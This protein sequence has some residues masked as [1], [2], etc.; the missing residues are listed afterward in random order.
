V[1][2]GLERIGAIL[3]SL[4]VGIVAVDASGNIELQNAEASR[5][6]GVSAKLARGAPLS[7]V[8]G[9]A[10]PAVALVA[11]ALEAQREVAAHACALPRR[12]L[13]EPPVVDLS[14]SPIGVGDDFEGVVLTLHDRT[15]G[16]ELQALLDQRTRSEVFTQLAAGIAHEVR[17]PLG[18]IRGA[19]ELLLGK[20]D[21]EALRR[22][23]ELIAEESERIRRLLDDLA[24][25]TAGGELQR[26]PINVHRVL[27]DLLELQRHD[28]AWREIE[29]VR[30]YDPSMQRRAGDVGHGAARRSHA[31]REPLPGFRRRAGAGAR[32]LARGRGRRS[33]HPGG[34]PAPCLHP[35][36][37]ATRARQRART[38]HRSA[39][40]RAPRRTAP[41]RKPP[42]RGHARARDASATESTMSRILVADDESSI[43]F[44]LREA[45][46]DRGHEVIEAEDGEEARRRL[47][48][49]PLDI[50]FLDI[51][52]PGASGLDLLA[53]VV[54]RGTEAPVVVIIT[55]QNTFENAIEAMKRGAFD[56][57]TKPFGLA[58]VHALVEKALRQRSL[59]S[60]VAE[61]RR[62]VGEVF[63]AGEALVGRS[64][65]MVETFKTIGRVAASEAAVLIRGESGT[66]KELIARAIHYHSAR[67]EGPFVAVNMSA[68]PSELVEAE[69]FG[70]ERGAF[71]GA[72]QARP[73]RFREAAGGTVLLDEIGDLSLPLQA[74]LLRV[75]QERE[76]TPLG[77]E[78][79]VAIDVRILAA[80]HQNLEEAVRAGGFRE[81]L[82]FRLNVVPIHVVP[83]RERREDIAVL[84]HH[85]V[86]RFS[87]ELGVRRRWPTED[88]LQALAAH[89]WPGNVR[90]LENVLKRGLVLASGDVLTDEDLELAARPEPGE[91]GDWAEQARRELAGLLDAPEDAGTRPYWSFVNRLER[92]II[93]EALVRC[94]GNQIRAARRLGIN[95]NTLRKKVQELG[96]A[97]PEP[98]D[99]SA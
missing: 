3:D 43:R 36:L 73:G 93:R 6:L 17:N 67:R 45:L 39:L 41:A 75:L 97:L 49:E 48:A 98:D 2:P 71:T 94:G 25:L 58:Q 82:Y 87:R 92:T 31:L 27:D 81:D 56:Y 30:E 33:R 34:R 38:R 4:R 15:T 83:L 57:L 76:V 54:A 65:A 50:A 66:G 11:R 77:G 29:L 21:D 5:I 44:V 88:A 20:L 32:R 8:L 22:Y 80:T 84:V 95:R 60:E 68:I 89:D 74:K 86:E 69:L 70:H 9:D 52:M 59:R 12:G 10:H 53:E 40:D 19:A 1:S 78:R 24:E 96:I 37:H 91:A 7:R 16:L 99:R 46:E 14:A 79:S 26:R 61:L 18:G 28:A 35:L 64:D 42:R 13:G 63:R 62:R 51:R 47:S 72:T 55:A 90:E 23:P 85:F